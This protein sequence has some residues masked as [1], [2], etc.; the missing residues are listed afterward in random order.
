MISSKALIDQTG[1]SRATLN[2]YIQLGILPKPVVQSL[3]AHADEGGARVLGFFP[4]DALERVQAV[5]VLK[6]QGLSMAQLA[7][8]LSETDILLELAESKDEIVLA[9]K[10]KAEKV[11]RRV[12]DGNID[13]T[14]KSSGGLN[15]SLEGLAHPAYMLNYN[16][17]LTWFNE[18]ARKEIFGFHVPPARSEQRNLLELLA[19]PESRLSMLDQR[20]LTSLHL[21][22]A[23]ARVSYEALH[24]A[25]E[26]ADAELLPL[27]DSID[28]L[29]TNPSRTIFETEFIRK[30]S[31]GEMSSYQ[32]YAVYFREGILIV[33]EPSKDRTDDLLSFLGRRDQV[34]ATLLS[35]RLPV[36][37]PLAVLVADLQHSVRICS[38]LPPDEYFELINQIWTTMGLILRK[39]AGTHG[40]HVG[41]GVVYYFLPQAENSYLFNAVLCADELR[42]AMRK[43]SAEWEVRKN[44]LTKLQL[45]IGLHEGQEWLGTFQSANHLEVAVLGNTINQAARLSDFA[46]HG[47]IWATKNL[48]SQLK[49]EE[50]SQLEFGVLRES[51]KN[52]DRFVVSSY[53]QIESLMD[54]KQDK[55]EKLRDIAQLVVTEVRRI[56]KV[57]L[58]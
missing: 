43:I 16:L 19:R 29:Q 33:H 23:S 14:A 26:A 8:R 17:E 41:D 45:N 28:F 55:H 42:L 24:S 46:R 49:P 7:A 6:A 57:R 15:V 13:G 56:S 51:S 50:Q 39:Y 9:S 40:K 32:I 37:T 38:E 31:K 1:I 5:Q 21:Q 58:Y 11:T 47:S 53:A 2:N 12:L 27:L 30:N 54:L 36:L 44:W 48:I 52:G 4:E 35:K 25:L 10:H 22:I 18:V 3:S 20:T 34:I